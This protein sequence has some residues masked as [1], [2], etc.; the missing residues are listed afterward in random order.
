MTLSIISDNKIYSLPDENEIKNAVK[1][2]CGR[3]CTACESPVEYAWRKREVDLSH[4][5][6]I[7]IENEL[8]HRE[9]GIIKDI[10]FNDL[11]AADV[12]AKLSVTPA[13]VYSTLG[14]ALEKLKKVLRYVVIYQQDYLGPVDTDSKVMKALDVLSAQRLPAPDPGSKL[15]NLREGRALSL[16]KV[17]EASG[18]GRQT[19]YRLEKGEKLPDAAE[20]ISLCRLYNISPN[21]LLEEDN[22]E[23]NRK[24]C[25]AV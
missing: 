4:L 20:I 7:A 5:V 12:A 22:N 1:I 13:A 8:T 2:C 11:S 9:K 23:H 21:Q 15:R 19:L 10:Y 14:R 17:S 25:T 6:D 3:C 24:P 18:I 16:T